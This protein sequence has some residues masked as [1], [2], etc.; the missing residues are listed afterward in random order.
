MKIQQILAAGIISLV[1]FSSC[2]MKEELWGKNEANLTMGKLELGVDVKQPASIT[3]AETTTIDTQTYPVSIVGNTGEDGAEVR[4]DYATLSEVPA[5]IVL[6]VG[7]YIVSSHT[8]GDIE[9]KMTTPYYGGEEEITIDKDIDTK[10]KVTCKMLNSRIQMEYGEDFI[11]AFSN[12][13][14]TIDDGSNTVLT[15]SEKEGEQGTTPIY[16]LF[17]TNKINA[18]KVNIR[19]TT[20][21]GNTVSEARTFKKSD[22]SGSYGDVSEF[23]GGGD[24]LVI[25]MG[26]VES[27]NGHVTGVTINTFIT[28]ENHEDVV[29]IPTDEPVTPEPEPE[30]EPEPGEGITMT[31][32]VGGKDLFAEGV[33]YSIS[34]GLGTELPNSKINISIPDKLQNMLVT[35]VAGNEGFNGIVEDMSFTNRDLTGTDGNGDTDLS[36]LLGALGIE[37]PMPKRGDTSYD[38]PIGTFYSLMNLYEHTINTGDGTPDFHTFQIKV[39]DQ[40]GNEKEVSLKVTINQ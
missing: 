18:I 10:A 27:T 32:Q 25:K 15:Y 40:N 33:E 35:I 5:T 19:A 23:F 20:T 11:T 34:E 8:P 21:Q 7:K 4:R 9:K 2:E 29:E 39:I 37:L 17:D 1:G 22:A 3:R 26:A 12:W 31:Y 38:F 16:W 28:F 6:P 36:N 13:T 14:I 30:P 24:A